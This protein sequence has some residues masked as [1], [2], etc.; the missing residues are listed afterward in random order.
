MSDDLDE[1]DAFLKSLENERVGE[2]DVSHNGKMDDTEWNDEE[3]DRL[4]A[5]S[6]VSPAKPSPNNIN[7]ETPISDHSDP[8]VQVEPKNDEPNINAAIQDSPVPVEVEHSLNPSRG[9]SPGIDEAALKQL[10][11]MGYEKD[12]AAAALLQSQNHV[13]EAV[14]LLIRANQGDEAAAETASTTDKGLPKLPPRKEGGVPPFNAKVLQEKLST[15]ASSFFKNAG[16]FMKSIQIDRLVED[17]KSIQVNTLPLSKLV[18]ISD[19]LVS[20]EQIQVQMQLI[21]EEFETQRKPALP[22]ALQ[23]LIEIYRHDCNRLGVQPQT[24]VLHQ[25]K[26][27]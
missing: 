16:L 15:G 27:S 19:S 11:E 4:L 13:Q 12:I 22:L 1:V 3:V 24:Q 25:L 20:E 14:S 17:I 7:G 21:D 18:P 9:P 8:Q 5:E 23:S 26:V 6:G 10:E 2:K